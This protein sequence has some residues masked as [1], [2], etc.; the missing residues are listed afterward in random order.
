LARPL[1]HCNTVRTCYPVVQHTIRQLVVKPA[2]RAMPQFR[3]D[4][5]YYSNSFIL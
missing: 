5:E 3:T 1:L 4:S 2:T